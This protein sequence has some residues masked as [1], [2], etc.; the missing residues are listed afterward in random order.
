[1][2]AK[3][4]LQLTTRHQFVQPRPRQ[5]AAVREQTALARAIDALMAKHRE[6]A[7]LRDAIL[8]FF[9]ARESRLTRPELEAFFNH[10]IAVLPRRGATADLLRWAYESLIRIAVKDDRQKRAMELY[11]RY[12][13]DC[14]PHCDERFDQ[15]YV[16]GL[17]C[18]GS[19]LLPL[20]R[21]ERLFV[22]MQ[23]LRKTLPLPGLVA[24]C[25]CFRG[26][27]SYL[28]CSYL[29]EAGPGF[30]GRGYRIF[31][32]FAGLSE[33]RPEDAVDQA[34]PDAE[35]LRVMSRRG[36]FAITLDKVKRNLGEHP[37][38]E[39][40]PGWIPDSFPDE[41]KARYRFVHVDVDLYQPTL[42]SFEYFY[43]KLVPGGTIVSDDYNWPGARRAIETFVLRRRLKL[44]TTPTGQAY[45]KRGR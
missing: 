9:G 45:I 1:M 29:K 35:G 40:F 21:R 23:M 42:D 34:A 6:G 13:G 32:S 36:S 15:T 3:P 8:A 17:I 2:P 28:L 18:T 38:I 30:N 10:L 44:R 16:A 26:L 25:G 12:L 41:P 20:A 19:L 22:L 5:S 33:P 14:A 24:E 31:D 4:P 27:S 37:G 39:Y 43:P 11:K 7:A